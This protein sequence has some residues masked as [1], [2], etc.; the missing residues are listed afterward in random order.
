MGHK[1]RRP[2]AW[3]PHSDG[4]RGYLISKGDEDRQESKGQEADIPAD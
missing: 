3:H 2:S 4:E 1:Q